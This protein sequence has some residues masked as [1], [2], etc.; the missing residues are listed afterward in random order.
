MESWL[1]VSKCFKG[2]DGAV[3]S[4]EKFHFAG[5]DREWDV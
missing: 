3:A 5:K 2:A 1:E 4:P